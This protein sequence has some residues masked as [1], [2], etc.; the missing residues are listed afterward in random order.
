MMCSGVTPSVHR[1]SSRVQQRE[2][3]NVEL[4]AVGCTQPCSEVSLCLYS[5][6]RKKLIYNTKA[7][8]NL[9]LSLILGLFRLK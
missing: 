5:V 6:E 3:E 2:R 7:V 1:K 4:H 9:H 8:A